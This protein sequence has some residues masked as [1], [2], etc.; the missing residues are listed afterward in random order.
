MFCRSTFTANIVTGS[1]LY[2]L[3][4]DFV[5]TKFAL[6]QLFTKVRQVNNTSSNTAVCLKGSQQYSKLHQFSSDLHFFSKHYP[7]LI[8]QYQHNHNTANI[9]VHWLYSTNTI[10]I[11]ESLRLCSGYILEYLTI[12]KTRDRGGGAA[13]LQPSQIEI[14]KHTNFIDTMILDI[15]CGLPFG[16]NQPLKSADD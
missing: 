5:Q 6:D 11:K 13:M 14:L 4:T 10:K 3:S 2:S 16:Q 7:T 1:K 15:S 8:I 9:T 12:V